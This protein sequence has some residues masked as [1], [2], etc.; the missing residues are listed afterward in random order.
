GSRQVLLTNKEASSS[1]STVEEP[2]EDAMDTHDVNL[3]SPFDKNATTSSANKTEEQS[4][5]EMDTPGLSE[6]DRVMHKQITDVL[7]GISNSDSE[8]LMQLASNLLQKNISIEKIMRIKGPSECTQYAMNSLSEDEASEAD[9][10]GNIPNEKTEVI[11]FSSSEE[12]KREED[13]EL[14]AGGCK[15]DR[16]AVLLPCLC[17][18]YC[19]DCARERADKYGTCPFHSEDDEPEIIEIKEALKKKNH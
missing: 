19:I 14:C 11:R 15:R 3:R 12:E 13:D 4:Q 16:R 8:S 2:S 1:R 10:N 7:M 18:R 5:D 9:E 17:F 6:E